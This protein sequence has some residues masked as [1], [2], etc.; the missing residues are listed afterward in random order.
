MNEICVD[1]SSYDGRGTMSIILK[2][3]SILTLAMLGKIPNPLLSAAA[4]LFEFAPKDTP[5]SIKEIGE[6]LHIVAEAA[7]INP[8]YTEV[9]DQLTDRQLMEIYH[10]AKEGAD[11]LEYFRVISELHKSSIGGEDKQHGGKQNAED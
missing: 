5:A 6:I 4:K 3:P 2:R 8:S 11:G 9:K 1:I 7:L 10:Y